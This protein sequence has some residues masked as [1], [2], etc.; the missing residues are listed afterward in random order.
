MKI[1]FIS[2]Y[3]NHH[4]IPFSNAM[5]DLLG[6]EYRFV[7]TAPMGQE[8]AELGYKNMDG[9]PYE[10]KSYAL[11]EDLKYCYSLADTS[12]VVIIGSAPDSFIADRLKEGKLTF[13]YAERFYKT[14]TS[15]RKLPRHFIGAW[16]HHGRF[17]K[18]PLYMLCASAYTAGDAAR[19]GNYLGRCYKWGY[20]PETRHYDLD[21]LFQKKKSST[22][23][24]AGRLIDWK[25]P[26]Y[27]VEAAA[28]LQR[29]GYTFEL[30]MIG[31]GVMENELRAMIAEKQ[32]EDVVH[33]L[34]AMP[35]EKVREHMEQ[36]SIFLFTSDRQEGWGA[37]LNESMNSGCAVVACSA[38]GSV[39]FLLRNG[40]N[41]STYPVGDFE[42]FYARLKM[43][44]DDSEQRERC[45][46]AAYRTIT[47]TWCAEVAAERLLT[48]A[49]CLK[50]GEDTPFA[51]GPCS[52][53]ENW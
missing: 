52:K 2:N 36:A 34:G 20:F 47:E 5:Y 22:L 27:A 49:E 16:M 40:E 3:L 30:N 45:G 43:L 25:H 26:E 42:T 14:G 10:I 31:S 9:N 15:L 51:D 28:R 1:T 46:R 24:W 44:L 4:Q 7:A 37:V 19:F 35:P 12:D 23:L 48:L 17:Q 33:L 13:K 41:G 18:Y 11:K 32:L 8:R 50:K 39:P 29:D 21:S 6:G 53:A 38:I